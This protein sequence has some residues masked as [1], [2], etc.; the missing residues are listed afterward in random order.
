MN[1][2]FAA[3]DEKAIAWLVCGGFVLA[4]L[5]SRSTLAGNVVSIVKGIS[6]S[7]AAPTVDHSISDR[8]QL[9]ESLYAK[10]TAEGCTLAAKALKDLFPT[11]VADPEPP[12][13]GGPSV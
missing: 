9:W 1:L 6:T 7:T 10:C 5:V 13:G 11:L 3:L 4:W 12:A 8:V 2:I